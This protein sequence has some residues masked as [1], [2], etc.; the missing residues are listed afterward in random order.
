MVVRGGT[1]RFDS[2]IRSSTTTK[3]SSYV[4][5]YDEKSSKVV[6]G[7]EDGGDTTYNN[8]LFYIESTPDEAIYDP[9]KPETKPEEYVS[10]TTKKGIPAFEDL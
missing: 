5:I 1:N 6:I 3:I 10:T 4:S 7:F 8:V 2:R 9:S